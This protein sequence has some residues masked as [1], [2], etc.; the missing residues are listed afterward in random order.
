MDLIAMS[1]VLLGEFSKM[2]RLYLQ[3]KNHKIAK[4]AYKY[5]K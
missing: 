4:M 2:D 1:T 5:D 3:D